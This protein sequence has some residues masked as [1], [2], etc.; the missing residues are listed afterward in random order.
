MGSLMYLQRVCTSIY[1][2]LNIYLFIYLA[3]SGLRHDNVGS[4]M[5]HSGSF[6]GVH[7]FSFVVCGFSS[8]G[9]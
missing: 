5:H 7:G 6:V 4:L 1:K 8:F 2:F 9:G 3:G